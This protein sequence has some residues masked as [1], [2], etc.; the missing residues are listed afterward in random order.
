MSAAY[1]KITEGISY[2][3]SS[4]PFFMEMQ[5]AILDCD[6]TLVNINRS[7]NACIKK[8]VGFLLERIVGGKQWYDLVTDEIILRF[9]MSGGFNNDTDTSYA[10][11][12]SAMASGAGDIEAA[13]KFVLDVASHATDE[14]IMSVEEHL[15]GSGRADA[16][17][18]A[19]TELAYPGE[20][21][22]SILSAVFDEFFYGRDLFARL[23]GI[24]PRFNN[25]L[26]LIEEDEVVITHESAHDLSRI[27]GGKVAIVSGRSRL[28][29]EYSLKTIL[30]HFMIGASVFLEDEEREAMRKKLSKR[31]SKPEPYAVLK[32]MDAMDVKSAISV[33]DSAEDVIMSRRAGEKHKIL[34]CGV[35]GTGIDRDKQ[36]RMF[37]EMGADAVIENVNQLSS[38]L[39]EL[40]KR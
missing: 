20:V 14:G 31:I 35:Y 37:V 2:R 19:K 40:G 15:S 7:Y 32:S 5:S 21:G 27:F 23:H 3:E 30:H 16:V 28:A 1:R 25:S 4:K 10:C 22:S 38:L 13:R 9:R 17:R 36:F 34:F 24:E 12:L 11:I 8:T 26:G 18:K 6:G 29:T 33:G 39:R